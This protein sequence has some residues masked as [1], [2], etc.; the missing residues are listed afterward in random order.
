[1]KLES[2]DELSLTNFLY[3]AQCGNCGAE[4]FSG[5]YQFRPD[6]DGTTYRVE[7]PEC[8]KRYLANTSKV[9]IV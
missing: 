3:D 8:E 2:G 7:C 5:D 1:M 6:P 4:L 9:N